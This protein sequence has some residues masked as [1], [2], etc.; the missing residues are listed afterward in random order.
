M[1]RIPL[2]L[3]IAFAGAHQAGAQGLPNP[4]TMLNPMANPMPG[5]GNPYGGY[6]APFGN[7]L[8]GLNGLNALGTLGSLGLMAA[9]VIVPL[10]PTLLNPMGQ[11]GYPA[12]QMAPNAMS[13]SH[14][15][16]SGGGPFSGNPYLRPTLPNPMVPPAFS[17]SMP[18]LPFS[19]SQGTLP[20][21]FGVPAPVTLP[22]AGLLPGLT[23]M[24]PAAPAASAT[25]Q[26]NPWAQTPA[27]PAPPAATAPAPLPLDPAVFMQMFMKPAEA[28]T[29]PP[30]K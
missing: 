8:G 6:G 15:M 4:L 28:L 30:G 12:M 22:P 23:P 26:S 16:Q 10:A 5:Y 17:P 21:P 29:P 25:S 24:A 14:Y 3:L 11:I 2:L 18:T 1:K 9:P 20:L 13:Y 7:P 27:Q 19:P